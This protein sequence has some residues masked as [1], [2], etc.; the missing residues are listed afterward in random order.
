MLKEQVAC[1]EYVAYQRSQGHSDLVVTPSG[2]LVCEEHHFLG[3]SPDSTVYNPDDTQHPFG[4]LEVKCPYSQRQMTPEDACSSSGFCCTASSG[5]LSLKRSHHYYAQ[6][7]GQMA[8][9][10]RPWCDFVI[11]TT[12]GISVDRIYFDKAYWDTLLSK[13][14]SFYNN[15]V[16]PEVVSPVQVLGLPMRDLSKT[17]NLLIVFILIIIIMNQDFQ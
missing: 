3:A 9:A 12:L 14:I 8:I 1:K 10:I 17:Q 15:C 6:V 16:A 5:R 4:L 11:Y 13:L 7:Q 2:F